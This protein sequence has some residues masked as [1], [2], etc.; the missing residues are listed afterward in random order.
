MTI[1]MTM[2][3]HRRFTITKAIREPASQIII[4]RNIILYLNIKK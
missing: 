2:G 3:L 1:T 4:T